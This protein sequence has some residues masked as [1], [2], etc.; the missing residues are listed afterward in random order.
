MKETQEYGQAVYDTEFFRCR[1]LNV[2]YRKIG[3][4]FGSCRF[5]SAPHGLPAGG[6][7]ARHRQGL[8]AFRLI[9]EFSSR[10]RQYL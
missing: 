3:R 10:L 6:R 1:A 9:K 7:L 2:L 5:V 8:F 4:Y